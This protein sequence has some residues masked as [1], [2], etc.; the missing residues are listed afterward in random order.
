MMFDEYL[1]ENPWIVPFNPPNYT[2]AKP[3]PRLQVNN[4]QGGYDLGQL[5]LIGLVMYATYRVAVS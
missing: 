2:I 4:G 1:N 5:L 3:I